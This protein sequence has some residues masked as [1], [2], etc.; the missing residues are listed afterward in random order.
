MKL[1]IDP[2]IFRLQ[3]FGGISRI[4]A[5]LL[6]NFSKRNDIEAH[7]FIY[8]TENLHLINYNLGNTFFPFKFWRF[9][10]FRLKNYLLE[11]SRIKTIK[12]LENGNYDVF[13]PT[14]YDTS[15]LPF[16][17]GTPFVLVVYDMIHELYPELEQGSDIIHNKKQL[18]ERANQIIA[19]SE[20]TKQDIIRF[21]PHIAEN[22]IQ[23]VYLSSTLE[24]KELGDHFLRQ[25]TD[26]KEYILFVGN[27]GFY[28]NFTW[29]L[30][31][32]SPW[33]TKNNMLLLCLGGGNFSQTEKDLIE[34]LN[35]THLVK[36]YTFRD[37]E[38][39]FFYNRA[40]LFVF[41][42]E[43]EGFGIPVLEAMASGCPVVLPNKSSF[44][45]V[46]GD[47][48][49]YY[50]FD[51]SDSL[52]EAIDSVCSQ[53]ELRNNFIQKG[54]TQSKKF[55][56]ENTIRACVEVFKVTTSNN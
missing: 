47:A 32:V 3:R 36:Q 42:S 5:E 17:N 2:L 1:L 48:G 9:F 11:K 43:Y 56:W 52:L 20:N 18:I 15:F 16:L 31:S 14:Y 7:S 26:G 33:L 10:P 46:A 39:Y 41:P 34:S 27:R 51:D 21:Y 28:K 4:Y 22:K 37:N 23:V 50:D 40:K 24:D 30:Q 29:F 55:S 19:I 25:L 38:L 6:F 49:I 53:P 13:V 12:E 44:P 35:L 8:Y 54:L 45:E